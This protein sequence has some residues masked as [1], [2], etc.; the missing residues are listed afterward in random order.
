MTTALN[1]ITFG[2]AAQGDVADALPAGSEHAIKPLGGR[3]MTCLRG[4]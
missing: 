2:D 1:L 3:S 4:F